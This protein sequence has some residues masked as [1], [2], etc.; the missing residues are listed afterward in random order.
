MKSTLTLAGLF[1]ATT[2]GLAGCAED[3]DEYYGSE[4]MRSDPLLTDPYRNTYPAVPGQTTGD[5]TP[6]DKRTGGAITGRDVTPRERLESG[7]NVPGDQTPGS[8]RPVNPNPNN[9]PIDAPQ[10]QP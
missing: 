8:V 2:L 1:V 6:V 10:R 4:N 5:G 9:A 7:Q 3:R